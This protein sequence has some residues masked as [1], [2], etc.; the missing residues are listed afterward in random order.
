MSLLS[1]IRFA[2]RRLVGAASFPPSAGPAREP[3]AAAAS[4]FRSW[5]H[6]VA[7]APGAASGSSPQAFDS[8]ATETA[9]RCPDQH[10]V[11]PSE[12]VLP[13]PSEARPST[14]PAAA[15]TKWLPVID[16][17]RCIGCERCIAACEH[18]CLEMIWSF[19]TLTV[20]Q[21]CHGEGHCVE[22]CPEKIIR[23]DWV[24]LAQAAKNAA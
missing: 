1:W 19:S 12:H 9:W 14:L 3:A 13:P 6:A 8:R 20:P 2:P 7:L 4:P 18:G 24:P 10:V 21:N 23:M 22:A 15:S 11:E 17:D 16:T 5:S